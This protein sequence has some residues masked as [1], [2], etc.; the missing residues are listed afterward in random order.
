VLVEGKKTGT[1]T[2]KSKQLAQQAAAREALE[3]FEEGR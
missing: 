3:K 2:G 1:G